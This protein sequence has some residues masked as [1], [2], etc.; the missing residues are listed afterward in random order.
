VPAA[1]ATSIGMSAN[2]FDATKALHGFENP[3]GDLAHHHLTST[4]ALHI[5]LCVSGA[6]QQTPGG[7]GRREPP[8]QARRE[9]KAED[10]QPFLD[11]RPGRCRRQSGYS[12][13]RRFARSM[14]SRVPA[15][16]SIAYTHDGR[17]P[18]PRADAVLGGGR[19]CS[20]ACGLPALDR[21]GLAEDRAGGPVERQGDSR[22]PR[23]PPPG[24]RQAGA[25]KRNVLL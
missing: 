18:V 19:E 17:P 2:P 3:R 12:S 11:P 6:T 15:L 1:P 14:S 23:R 25:H 22:T 16:R 7:L 21:R 8:L 13:S 24:A 4:P 10:R 9:V 5:P 20:A